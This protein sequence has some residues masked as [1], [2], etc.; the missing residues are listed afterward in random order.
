MTRTD[1]WC[2]NHQFLFSGIFT[3]NCTA[4]LL[5]HQVCLNLKSATILTPIPMQQFVHF[6]DPSKTGQ[7]AG[8][9]TTRALYSRH[10][11]VYYCVSYREV[12]GRVYPMFDTLKKMHFRVGD[13]LRS[14]WVGVR[15]C[16]PP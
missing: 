14:T 9:G 8:E 10:C 16:G 13:Y 1:V 7:G 11:G 15:D 6:L 5:L 12:V 3:K 2:F 4:C